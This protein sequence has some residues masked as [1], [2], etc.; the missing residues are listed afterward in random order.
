MKTTKKD[1]AIKMRDICLFRQ[2]QEY[3]FKHLYETKKIS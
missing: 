1:I 2:N 3:Y